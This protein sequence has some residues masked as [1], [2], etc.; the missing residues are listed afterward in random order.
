LAFALGA[1][2]VS[3]IGMRILLRRES[4]V[5]AASPPS[6]VLVA[7]ATVQR[8]PR[9]G[10]GAATVAD[11][12][13]ANDDPP[14]RMQMNAHAHA[15]EFVRWMR[16]HGFAGRYSA[17][18]VGNWYDWFTRDTRTFPIPSNKFLGALNDHPGVGKERARLKD[19][20]GRVIK[21]P[22]GTP[23]R[24]M[25]Y[26]IGEEVGVHVPAGVSALAAK[27]RQQ[28]VGRGADI[29]IGEEV[30]PRKRAAA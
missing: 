2:A 3:A 19:E 26:T 20:N 14:Y 5:V 8:S 9:S 23:A 30:A 12:G 24:T 28:P 15:V 17:A 11:R 4:R 22:S 10:I 16:D 29:V 21:L 6:R 27:K 7:T 25:F 18:E 1:M 13:P